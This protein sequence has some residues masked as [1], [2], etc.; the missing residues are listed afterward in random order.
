M[1]YPGRDSNPY[2]FRPRGLSSTC[3]RPERS[4]RVHVALAT[5]P[6]DPIGPGRTRPNCNRNCNHVVSAAEPADPVLVSL[7]R[8]VGCCLES[9]G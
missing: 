1:M 5:R 7:T 4:A 8:A 3:H 6:S 2:A 9:V